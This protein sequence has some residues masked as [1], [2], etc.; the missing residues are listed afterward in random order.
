MSSYT[1]GVHLVADTLDELHYFAQSIGLK[2]NY[3]EGVR[4]GHP[5]YDLT[6]TTISEK[7]INNGAILI[8]SKK[9]LVISKNLL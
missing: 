6:N 5:H 3:Y 7:A 8:S 4:K 1:D 9:L 2:R